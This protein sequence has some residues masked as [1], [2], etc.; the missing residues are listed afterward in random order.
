MLT[1][2]RSQANVHD[3]WHLVKRL[4]SL[5]RASWLCAAVA[6]LIPSPGGREGEKL[7]LARLRKTL[8]PTR[9]TSTYAPT[10]LLDG[11]TSGWTILGKSVMDTPTMLMVAPTRQ[12]RHNFTAAAID[13]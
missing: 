11:S 8:M 9:F 1:G 5:G 6:D 7:A 10:L 4:D 2:V 13:A 12:G 3:R